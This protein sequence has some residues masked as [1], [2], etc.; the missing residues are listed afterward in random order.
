MSYSDAPCRPFA[1]RLWVVLGYCPAKVYYRLNKLNSLAWKRE[2]ELQHNDKY[3]P[4]VKRRF[5]EISLIALFT[6]GAHNSFRVLIKKLATQCVKMS[7]FWKVHTFNWCKGMAKK[8][9]PSE[10]AI[11][12]PGNA[13]VSSCKSHYWFRPTSLH[14]VWIQH[15]KRLVWTPLSLKICETSQRCA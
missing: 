10:F 11:T 5:H 3:F 14:R 7:F 9:V 6:K 2:W 15:S 1:R 12:V 8:Y 13:G 4:C